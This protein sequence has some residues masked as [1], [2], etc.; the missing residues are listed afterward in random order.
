V[1]Q[2]DLYRSEANHLNPP[3][4]GLFAKADQCYQNALVLAQTLTAQ[5]PKVASVW[6]TLA[7]VEQS[8][9]G[10]ASDQAAAALS[11]GDVV[12][13]KI[14]YQKANDQ[15]ALNLKAARQA[16]AL[17]T[18]AER[19]GKMHKVA[20]VLGTA[21]YDLLFVGQYAAALQDATAAIWDDPTEL[22]VTTNQAHALLLEGKFDEAWAI[23]Q[24][25][26]FERIY[27]DDKETFREAVLDDFDAFEKARAFFT[28]QQLADIEKARRQLQA[29]PAPAPASSGQ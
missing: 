3:P 27:S 26:A 11:Q 4:P 17:A 14:L 10:S 8:M 12:R 25:H 16:L 28:P 29:L 22:W 20:S 1:N 9:D 18:G 23:Y 6:S 15:V 13:A 19:S 7:E 24:Q 21:S 2:G 5:Y